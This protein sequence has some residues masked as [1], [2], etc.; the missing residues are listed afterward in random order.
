ME[1]GLG[2]PDLDALLKKPKPLDFIFE[3][4]KVEQPGEYKQDP[5]SLTSEEQLAEIPVLKQE[6]NELYKQK[7]F[8][9]AIEKYFF[10]CQ[11]LILK[12]SSL[13]Y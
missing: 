7:K 4:V 5:W 9:E 8:S 13:I 3:V 2:Y 12:I 6:G 11:F 1:H 10:F